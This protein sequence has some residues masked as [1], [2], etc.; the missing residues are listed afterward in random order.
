MQIQPQ[1]RRSLFTPSSQ[2]LNGPNICKGHLLGEHGCEFAKQGRKC[3]YS[4]DLTKAGLPTHD[5]EALR[6]TIIMLEARIYRTVPSDLAST[7]RKLEQSLEQDMIS[8][9][10]FVAQ[11]E[12]V[13]VK[14]MQEAPLQWRQVTEKQAKD[15]IARAVKG[16]FVQDAYQGKE[17]AVDVAGLSGVDILRACGVD[18]P[19]AN[20]DDRKEHSDIFAVLSEDDDDEWEDI[21]DGMERKSPPKKFQPQKKR[22]RSSRRTRPFSENDMEDDMEY[23]MGPY[24]FSEDDIFEHACQGVKPWDD[25]A[26]DVLAMLNGGF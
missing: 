3:W 6:K 1:A 4:H 11:I 15:T 12:S 14:E 7:V 2:V 21:D 8:A 19:F 16:E 17:P 24:G 23:G 13:Q 25:D 22:L 20:R 9:D 18:E 10:D 5:K 26:G